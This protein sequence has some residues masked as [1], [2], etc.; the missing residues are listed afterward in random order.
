MPMSI[1]A[2]VEEGVRSSLDPSTLVGTIEICQP[3]H[4]HLNGDILARV[5]EVAGELKSAGARALVLCSEGKNFC[6]GANFGAMSGR[7]DVY[8]LGVQIVAQPLPI[9]AAVQGA[10]VGGGVGLALA[11]DLRITTP[12]SYFWINFSRLGLHHGFG[13]SVTLPRA[14]GAQKALE[15]LYTSRR[16]DGTAAFE[17]G[18][19]DEVVPT[20]TLR[21]RAHAVAAEI[22]SNAPLA[23]REIRR[24]MR[25]D[26]ASQMMAAM[27]AEREVQDKLMRTADFREGTAAVR[28]RRSPVFAAN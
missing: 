22:A 19:C 8:E 6:A 1:E 7:A 24:T 17:I 2:I 15:L 5:L 18:L 26:L 20:E 16:I 3:P 25:G 27:K 4:N 9:V 21:D 13:L 23:V 12:D 14:V 11:A 10:T 28:E